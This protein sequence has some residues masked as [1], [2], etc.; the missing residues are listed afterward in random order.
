MRPLHWT[1]AAIMVAALLV[2]MP[3]QAVAWGNEGHEIVA[4]IAQAY[5]APDV[6]KK[7][8]ALLAADTDP[9][10]AHDMA[11][12][13]T[14]ADKLRESNEGGVRERTRQWHFVDIEIDAPNLDQA[15]FG[16]P[17]VP[18]G[19]PASRGPADDC[20]VDKIEAFTGE[21]R[22]PHTKP[23][24]RI[25]ALKFLMHFVGDVHQPLHAADANDRGGNRK[26]ASALGFK[27]GNLHRFWDTEFVERLGA[28]PKTIAADLIDEITEDQVQAWSQGTASD[29]AMETFQ[30]AKWDAYGQLPQPSKRRSYRLTEAYV[31]TAVRDVAEQLSKSGVRL[32]MLLNQAFGQVR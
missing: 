28:D 4:L 12:E 5:L 23:E 16:H 14:W 8:D 21:L 25:L 3:R 17:Q 9:L 1:L 22:D 20:I 19:I 30:V 13:A 26:R 6:R 18:Q 32:A 31:A 24:E 15:C 11:S 7:V 29:W 10:T 2:S 27:A